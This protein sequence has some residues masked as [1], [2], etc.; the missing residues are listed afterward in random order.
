VIYLQL[1]RKSKSIMPKEHICSTILQS[2][3]DQMV[4]TINIWVWW[5]LY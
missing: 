1:Q 4:S 5:H 2:I 3:K